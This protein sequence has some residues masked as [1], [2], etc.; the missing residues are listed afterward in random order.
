MRFDSVSDLAGW[1]LQCV[2]K[3]DG[4]LFSREEMRREVLRME[5]EGALVLRRWPSG[6]VSIAEVRRGCL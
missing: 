1:A 2:R 6:A 4:G 5:R 3:P